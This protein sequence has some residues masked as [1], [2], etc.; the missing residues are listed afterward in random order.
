MHLIAFILAIW[1]IILF[2]VRCSVRSAIKRETVDPG[3][4]SQQENGSETSGSGL[5][6]APW[7]KAPETEPGP[8]D[9]YAVAL[10]SIVGSLTSETVFV[11][12][13]DRATFALQR[14]TSK[15]IYPADITML[16]TGMYALTVMPADTIIKPTKDDIALIKKGT[17]T[18]YV[19]SGHALTL[20]MLVEG[21]LI[22]GGSDCAYAVATA[23]GRYIAQNDSLSSEE[24]LSK[25]ILGINAYL[26][27]I[28]CPGTKIE[29]PD[30]YSGNTHYTTVHDLVEISRLAVNNEYMSRYMSIYQ[31]KVYYASGHSMTWTN[32]NELLNPESVYFRGADAG[33]ST[34]VNGVK[35]GSHDGSYSVVCSVGVDGM[36]KF[37][38][39]V[40][41]AGAS[42]ARFED[43]C[44]IVDAIEKVSG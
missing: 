5:T 6:F 40:F 32:D 10:A 37:L 17:G 34:F 36:T 41:G 38:V 30:G 15:V 23:V 14:G 8:E 35:A 7:T 42:D 13:L 44:K 16:W 29:T 20:A 31:T 27:D 2:M 28:N 12:D 9:P 3:K 33:R 21:M 43:A 22:D 1:L 26:T 18:A 39:G 11:Y 24:A 25:F 4:S 19:R